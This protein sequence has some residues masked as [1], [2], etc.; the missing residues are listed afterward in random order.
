MDKVLRLVA[1][2]GA[3]FIVVVASTH[4]LLGQSWIP[5]TT[6][7]T[8]TLDSEHRFYSSLFLMYGLALGWCAQDIPKRREVFHFLLLTLF[9]GGLTRV[10]SLVAAGWPHPMFVVLG[11]VELIVPPV[12]WR[13][14]VTAQTT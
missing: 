7:V 13:L 14:S 6:A 3:L 10:V 12:V 11:A 8:P 9:V 5:G 2:A 1:L 4:I